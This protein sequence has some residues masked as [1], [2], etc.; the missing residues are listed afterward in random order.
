VDPEKD[1]RWAEVERRKD[2]D[3][4]TWEVQMEMRE[5]LLEGKPVYQGYVHDLHSPTGFRDRKIPLI[6]RSTY[7]GGWDL[8][9]ASVRPA[10]V[11][12]Q[13][14]PKPLRQVHLLMEVTSH[15]SGG[16]NAVEFVP[17]AINAVN[18]QYP[19]ISMSTIPHFGD[20]TG[21]NRQGV[22]GKTSFD[23]AAESGIAIQP[24]SN[25]WGDR[26]GAVDKLLKERLDED[27]QP[28]L[29]LFW[30]CGA[31]C[32]VIV[33]GFRGGYRLKQLT[34]GVNAL[35]G[36]PVKD[37]FSDPHDALQYAAIGAWLYMDSTP[38]SALRRG[39]TGKKK[40]R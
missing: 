34:E 9:S 3:P 28:P 29:P 32:P 23:I 18:S 5:I 24:V 14:T 1:A 11:L 25:R 12:L 26:R 35:F 7:I 40:R 8:G 31:H 19:E 39:V 38:T 27:R 30:V 15:Q 21:R 17:A 10:F 22:T 4:R 13:I 20:E 36:D 2:A 16:T 37:H 6:P 33:H